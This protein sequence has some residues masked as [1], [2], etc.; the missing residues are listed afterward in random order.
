[1]V[2]VAQAQAQRDRVATQWA[3]ATAP[4]PG[5]SQLRRGWGVA[6]AHPWAVGVP[7]AAV[8]VLRPRWLPVLAR[9][10]LSAW[11]AARRFGLLSR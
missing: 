8:F 10:L 9:G 6:R 11:F 4:P 3:A 5:W 7:V 2:L 1:M